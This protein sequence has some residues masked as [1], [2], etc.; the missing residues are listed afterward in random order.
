MKQY[1]R[2]L[3]TIRPGVI[4]GS[5]AI[6]NG[7]YGGARH[8]YAAAAVIAEE[9]QRIAARAAAVRTLSAPGLFT[10]VIPAGRCAGMI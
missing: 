3:S 5:G 8:V 1:S 6:R 2:A 4:S 7:F 10:G 9:R